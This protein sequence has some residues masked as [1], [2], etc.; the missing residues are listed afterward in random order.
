MAESAGIDFVWLGGYTS[1]DEKEVFGH[2]VTGEDFVYEA[3]WRTEIGRE[4]GEKTGKTAQTGKAAAGS[5][6]KRAVDRRKEK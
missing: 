1:Y 5:G 6:R 2:R 3:W 4:T